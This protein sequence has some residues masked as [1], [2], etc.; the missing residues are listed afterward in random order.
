[1][2]I[3]QSNKLQDLENFDEYSAQ[4]GIIERSMPVGVNAFFQKLMRSHF[5]FSGEVSKDA[6]FLDI[7][8][9]LNKEFS[10]EIK[11][12]LLYDEWLEDMAEVCK[13][14]CVLEKI[15]AVSFHLGTQRACRR[16]HIDNVPKR[17]LVTYAGKGTEWL[18]DEA[19]DREA[20]L[21]GE[22][23]EKIIKDPS[24]LQFINQWDVAVFRG[25]PEGVLHRTP[26]AAL[27]GPSILMKLDHPEFLKNII[28]GIEIF[29]EY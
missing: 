26:D 6:A 15:E 10:Q 29:E 4:L 17:M 11:A 25:G 19:A 2:N 14:F 5:K 22:P 16:Y 7:R 21:S 9:I 24:A 20:F 1:M 13:T 12:E 27:N 23:N 18:P 3:Y 8:N 28:P